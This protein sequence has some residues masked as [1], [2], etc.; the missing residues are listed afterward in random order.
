VE[1]KPSGKFVLRLPPELHR[2]LK[3]LAA[4]EGV[5][6]NEL[7]LRAVESYAAGIP[8]HAEGAG[9]PRQPW[10]RAAKELLGRSLLGVVLFGST[11]RGDNYGSSDIDL[12]V[13]VSMNLPLRRRLYR[14]WD[15]HSEAQR[16]SPHF[17]HLPGSAAA[18][19]SVWAEAAVD[20]IVLYDTGG[21]VSRLLGQV[22][23][24]VASGRLERKRA[25]GHPY[26]VRRGEKR[27]AQ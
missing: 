10:L 16:Y 19:G 27:G 24:M 13:V 6:L 8:G 21:E 25:Y 7:C 1:T 11:A 14:L 3:N 23:R 26:W 22:R 9:G 4:R 20:G 2:T 5:S 15:E 17:V 18:A 12:L